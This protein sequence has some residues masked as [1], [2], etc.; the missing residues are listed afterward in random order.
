M[1]RSIA[2]LLGADGMI[3]PKEAHDLSLDAYLQCYDFFKTFW[4]NLI[5]G[6]ILIAFVTRKGFNEFYHFV[7]QLTYKVF[8]YQEEQR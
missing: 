6:F 2:T 8:G 7:H 3:S 4:K 5:L 1:T